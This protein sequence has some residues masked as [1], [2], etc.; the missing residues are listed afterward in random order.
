MSFCPHPLVPEVSV[1]SPPK[2]ATAKA[3]EPR[4]SATVGKNL[5]LK[6]RENK[7]LQQTN[8][9]CT[10]AMSR[11]PISGQRSAALKTSAPSELAT[12][13]SQVMKQDKD[14]CEMKQM[15]QNLVSTLNSKTVDNET[16]VENS[17]TSPTIPAVLANGKLVMEKG[18]QTKSK[19]PHCNQPLELDSIK[20]VQK[21][22]SQNA[23][24]L[25]VKAATK[26]TGNFSGK[27][28]Q[29][30]SCSVSPSERNFVNEMILAARKWLKNDDCLDDIDDKSVIASEY[31]QRENPNNR[32]DIVARKQNIAEESIP[33]DLYSVGDPW[34]TS[35]S[36]EVNALAMHYL[37]QN[38]QYEPSTFNAD[39]Y[40]PTASGKLNSPSITVTRRQQVF[41]EAVSMN[42]ILPAPTE[43][44]LSS[45]E[46]LQR[47]G[48]IPG[49]TTT[50]QENQILDENIMP[51]SSRWASTARISNRR[52]T[53]TD[54]DCGDEQFIR[55]PIPQRYQGKTVGRYGYNYDNWN[56]SNFRN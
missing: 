6:N 35:L 44:S 51:G 39:Q 22:S 31:V 43:M 30:S 9:R 10:S 26:S 12:L 36:M 38:E 48:I 11:Q 3:N 40:L 2:P 34:S 17:S 55:E 42:G 5:N 21:I 13:K 54:T 15:I 1:C 50:H 28:T 27:L 52:Y 56:G 23:E 7:P 37:K 53:P 4:S 19:C 33:Q 29:P 46:F 16:K 25:P 47:H 8:N 20:D 18:C 49:A 24:V 41:T 14:I 45:R 32:R